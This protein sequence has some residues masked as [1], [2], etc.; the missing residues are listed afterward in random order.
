MMGSSSSY[1]AE[2]AATNARA[3]FRLLE[4]AAETGLRNNGN[5]ARPM[6]RYDRGRGHLLEPRF[7]I[8]REIYFHAFKLR[9]NG[10]CGNTG[11]DSA[12]NPP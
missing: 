7:D 8:G 1:A 9:E 6:N 10:R 4:R 2:P 5:F 3:L 11:H 12:G